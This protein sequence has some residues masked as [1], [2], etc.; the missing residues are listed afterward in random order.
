VDPVP[1]RFVRRAI[2]ALTALGA[3]GI[4]AEL[5]ALEHFRSPEQLIAIVTTA[6]ALLTTA[7]AWCSPRL[8]AVRA[9]QFAMLVAI[10]S[11]I[12][13]MTLHYE[14]ARR[15][16]TDLVEP[17]RP[18]ALSPGVLVHLGLL[19]LLA[20]YRHPALREDEFWSRA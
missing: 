7:W 11:G 9:L 2:L 14:A 4:G 6:A 5:V 15:P 10:G 3:T 8:L 16:P 13:G 1:L 18:P 17:V 20:S 12:I 19:G